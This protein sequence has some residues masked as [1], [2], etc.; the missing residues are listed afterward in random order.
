MNQGQVFI[1]HHRDREVTECNKPAIPDT[2]T[3]V[4]P[5]TNT[6]VIPEIFYRRSQDSIKKQLKLCIT[7]FINI[8]PIKALEN[9]GMLKY[10]LA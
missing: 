2:S 8:F 9:D 6:L 7:L 5:E 1:F 10:G 3:P 4:I